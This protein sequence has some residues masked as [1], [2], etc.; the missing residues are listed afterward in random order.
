MMEF[1]LKITTAPGVEEQICVPEKT[2]LQELAE[3]YQKNY[4]LAI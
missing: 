4:Y 2:T 1:E 3:R